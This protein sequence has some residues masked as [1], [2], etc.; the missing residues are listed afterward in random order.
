LKESAANLA[1]EDFNAVGALITD[2]YDY[3]DSGNCT[4][5]PAI[6]DRFCDDAVLI[7]PRYEL[8]GRRAIEDWL[9]GRAQ[10]RTARTTRHS[11]SNLRVIVLSTGDLSAHAHLHI[12]IG[13]GQPPFSG[14]GIA[15]GESIDVLR[16]HRAGLWQFVERRVEVLFEGCLPPS[17]PGAP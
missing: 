9:V 10:Q 5:A 14:V 15:I 16:K 3:L 4:D 6:A 1:V 11:W 12:V 2:F 17:R 8:R 13:Q 7:T